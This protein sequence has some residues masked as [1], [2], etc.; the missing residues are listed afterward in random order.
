[1]IVGLFDVGRAIWFSNTLATAVRE[2]TRYGIVHGALSGSPTGP[3]AAS[4][5]AP[6]TDT[7][8]T[9][10]VRNYAYGVPTNLTVLST[11]PDGDA[12]RGSRIVVTATYPFTPILAQVFLGGGLG[13]TL[14]SS[15]TLVIEQ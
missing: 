1:M 15:S 2:G 6:D 13:I 14:R 4:Y 11:W 3:G 5:T 12:N 10:Q 8:I 9:A 7:T